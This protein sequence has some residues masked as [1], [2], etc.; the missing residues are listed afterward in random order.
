TLDT[1]LTAKSLRCQDLGITLTCVADGAELDFMKPTDLSVLFGNALDNAI[2]SVEKISNP[3]KRLIHLSIARQK[4]FLRIRVENCYEG[5]I[6]F[7]GGLPATAKDAKY[8][9]YGMKSIQSI[10]EKYNGS[11]TVKAEDGWFEL[12]VLFP[13]SS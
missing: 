8:H 7:V 13:I 5:E 11:M 6:S 1:L 2:E 12:R 9:G 3:D 10:V 4:A